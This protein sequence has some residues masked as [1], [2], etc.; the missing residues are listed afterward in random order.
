M[1]RNSLNTGIGVK[2]YESK[3]IKLIAYADDTVLLSQTESDFQCMAEVLMDE[4][5]GLTINE[6]KTKC[7]ILLRK[8]NRHSN[9][10]IRDMEFGFV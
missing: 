4:Q 5:M 1:V 8:S 6:E 7:M 9:L 10:I 3:T 2:L